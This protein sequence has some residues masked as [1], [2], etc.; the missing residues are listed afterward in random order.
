M[1]E[2]DI[3]HEDVLIGAVVGIFVG[4]GALAALEA[5]GVVI[6][7]DAAALDQHVGAGVQVH[8]VRAGRTDRGDGGEE[9]EIQ[10]LDMV[11][12]VDV[13]GPERGVLQDGVG[14]DHVGAVRNVQQARALLVLVGAGRIPLAAQA[15]SLPIRAAVAVDGTG[16]REGEA[17]QVVHI[18]QGG[19]ILAD[20]A[21]DAGLD[22]GKIADELTALEHGAAA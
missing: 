2:E 11:G 16:A 12:L 22:D 17:V 1:V 15:E 14:E 6:D 20:L 18:D 10:D 3:L 21:L 13:A 7:R 5:D 8:A 9:P 4:P 19:E